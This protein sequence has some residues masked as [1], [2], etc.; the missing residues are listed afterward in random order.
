MPDS[1]AIRRRDE[2][3]AS[4]VRWADL[5]G[6]EHGRAGTAGATFVLLHGLTFDHRMW[7][8]SAEA[9]PDDHR[10]IALSLPGHGGSPALSARG[11]EPVVEAINDAVLDEGAA[12]RS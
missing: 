11:L 12:A 4:R 5:A 8:P 7:D 6:R 3:C 1:I 9:L 10:A 2:P